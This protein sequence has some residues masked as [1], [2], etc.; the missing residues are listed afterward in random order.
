MYYVVEGRKAKIPESHSV[1]SFLEV[2]V[3]SINF[4]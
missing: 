3:E 4:T 1:E 2:D